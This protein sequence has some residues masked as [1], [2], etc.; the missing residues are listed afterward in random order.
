M[1]IGNHQKWPSLAA[2]TTARSSFQLYHLASALA[3]SSHHVPLP[4]PPAWFQSFLSALLTSKANDD[5]FGEIIPRSIVGIQR[6]S[7]AVPISAESFSMNFT[8]SKTS[9]SSSGYTTLNYLI[10]ECCKYIYSRFMAYRRPRLLQLIVAGKMVTIERAIYS[11]SVT[12]P[13]MTK[14]YCYL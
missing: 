3:L 10:I 14:F 12:P 13:V 11:L 8:P 5:F 9:N 7:N 4:P 2:M 1:Q 6:K